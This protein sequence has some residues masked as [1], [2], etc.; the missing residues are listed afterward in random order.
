MKT[1]ILV[2]LGL[3]WLLA[4][5]LFGGIIAQGVLVGSM[6]TGGILLTL[7]AI[8]GFWWLVR[9]S[10]AGGI[11][12]AILTAVLAH[13]ILGGHSV[14]AILA[15]G[16]AFLAKSLVLSQARAQRPVLAEVS[17]EPC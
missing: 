13:Q 7:G 9:H 14:T 6:V 15:A 11:F 5:I 8:P 3:P 17:G 4:E 2:T 1:Q 12:L 10:R 16:W